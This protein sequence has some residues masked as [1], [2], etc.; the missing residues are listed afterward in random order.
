MSRYTVIVIALMMLII[1][2]FFRPLHALEVSGRTVDGLGKPVEGVAVQFYCHEGHESPLAVEQ[3]ITDRHGNFRSNIEQLC[4]FSVFRDG[5]LSYD[6]SQLPQGEIIMKKD[7]EN[8]EELLLPLLSQENH[9]VYQGLRELLRTFEKS[10]RSFAYALFEFQ[11]T[12]LP[13]LRALLDEPEFSE[14]SVQILSYFS[15]P[16]D[17]RCILALARQKQGYYFSLAGALT[18]PATEEEWNYLQQC[19]LLSVDDRMRWHITQQAAL[20]LAVKGGDRAR[21]ILSLHPLHTAGS[22]QL[23]RS[24]QWIQSHPK[25]LQGQKE[26]TRS[27]EEAAGIFL[28]KGEEALFDIEKVRLDRT[29]TRGLV[30]VSVY[31]SPREARGY[32]MV[33]HK[34]HGIWVLKGIWHTWIA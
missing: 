20:A 9:E 11:E 14:D 19:I 30:S 3:V 4:W 8:I 23:H 1:P 5:Y 27:V 26:L 29:E 10:P 31:Q 24:L 2:D 18:S 15:Y 28:L 7:I 12:F 32:D 25:G 33:F 17:I 16:G 6:F 22:T 34:I 13:S 21:H